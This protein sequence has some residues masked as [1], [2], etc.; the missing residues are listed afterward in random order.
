MDQI[1]KIRLNYI[2]LYQEL[3]NAGLVCLRCGISRPTLRK[4]LKRYNL[5]GVEGLLDRSHKPNHSPAKKV[6]KKKSN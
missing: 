6:L 1:Q 3:G 5:Q 4:W 2:K